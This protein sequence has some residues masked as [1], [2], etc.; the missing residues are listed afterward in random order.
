LTWLWHQR[1][2]A[3]P[4]SAGSR[5]RSLAVLPLGNLSGNPDQNY[6]ADGMTEALIG[7]LSTIQGLR[8]ISR[9]SSMQFKAARSSEPEIARKLNVQAVVEGSVIRWGDRIRV[10][11]QLIK[12]DTDMHLWSGTFDRELRDVLS[13]ESEVAQSIARQIEVA[14]TG[15]ERSRLVAVRPVSPEV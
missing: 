6:L 15:Q 8:V 12:G 14:V 1:S 4:T 11:A 9:T 13:L 3:L 7:R 5:I 10:T 2:T